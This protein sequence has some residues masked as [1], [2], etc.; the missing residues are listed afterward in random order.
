MLGHGPDA[1]PS[2]GLFSSVICPMQPGSRSAGISD[3]LL[4]A[5]SR[6]HAI[7]GQRFRE[8]FDW[9]TLFFREANGHERGDHT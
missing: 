8:L 1:V 5:Y 4:L 6:G 2:A 9:W 3:R 7:F